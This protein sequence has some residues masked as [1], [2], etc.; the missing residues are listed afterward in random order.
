M[1]GKHELDDIVARA[2]YIEKRLKPLTLIANNHY[3]GKEATQA[4][5]I[6]TMAKAERIDVPPP[7]LNRYPEPRNL[8]RHPSRGSLLVTCAHRYR[9]LLV[10]VDGCGFEARRLSAF[11]QDA[12]F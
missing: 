6:K 1:Y 5:A 3:R 10:S 12:L 11:R 8:W 2:M 9:L 4:L 7:L